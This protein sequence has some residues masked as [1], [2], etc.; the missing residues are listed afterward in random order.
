[1]PMKSCTDDSTIQGQN[2]QIIFCRCSLFLPYKLIYAFIH[3]FIYS[4]L[5]ILLNIVSTYSIVG[6]VLG[7]RDSKNV[8]PSVKEFTVWFVRQDKRF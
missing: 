6:I 4:L 8:S 1:M 5:K 7:F 2:V 3:S